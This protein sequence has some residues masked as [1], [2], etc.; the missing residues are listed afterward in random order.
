MLYYG[1][2]KDCYCAYCKSL[3]FR[4]RFISQMNCSR[5]IKYLANFWAVHCNNVT[6][7]NCA[8]LN[9]SKLTFMGKTAKYKAFTV[10]NRVVKTVKLQNDLGHISLVANFIY[11]GCFSNEC[12]TKA[13]FLYCCSYCPSCAASAFQKGM[14]S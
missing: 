3:K 2:V 5:E 1:D 14:A 8:K 7:Q 4:V 13:V 11:W 6:S 9:S 10:Y 12:A